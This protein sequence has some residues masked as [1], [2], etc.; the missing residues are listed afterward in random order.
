MKNVAVLTIGEIARRLNAPLHRIEYLI[1][2]RGI[3]P[4]Q[5]AGIL[6]IFSEEDF[7]VLAAEHERLEQRAAQEEGGE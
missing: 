7:E 1:R 5:R 4:V 2:A 3:E 6:R